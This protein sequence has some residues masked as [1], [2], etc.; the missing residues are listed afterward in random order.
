ME[1]P[2]ASLDRSNH[3]PNKPTRPV[4]TK[5]RGWLLFASGLVIALVFGIYLWVEALKRGNAA[6]P[7]WLGVAFG[8]IIAGF[9]L[10]RRLAGPSKLDFAE[11]GTNVSE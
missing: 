5:P 11:G 9:G 8:L 7:L 4:D 10:Y 3:P 1:E 2:D 6:T